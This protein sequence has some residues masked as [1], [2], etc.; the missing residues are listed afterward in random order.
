MEIVELNTNKDLYKLLINAKYIGHGFTSVCFLLKNN[1]VLKIYY[2]SKHKE[3]LFQSKNMIDYFIKLNKI[4]NNS[5]IVPNILYLYKDE[6]IAYSYPYQNSLMLSALSENTKI[7]DLIDALNFL[8]EDTIT[9]S[10]FGFQ[11][12]DMTN[13]NI[14]Y[15]G[16]FKIIDLDYGEFANYSYEFL[17]DYNQRLILKSIIS[18]IFLQSY[19]ELEFSNPKLWFAA[20]IMLYNDYK[21]NYEFFRLIKEQLGID[22]PTIRELRKNK[23]GLLINK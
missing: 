20:K 17:C 12:K 16:I 8:N 15:D 4:G 11:N 18:T 5:Y 19:S 21:V 2:N 13:H 9:I 22:N 6:L 7:N 23:K 3:Q 14:L 1:T 10:N